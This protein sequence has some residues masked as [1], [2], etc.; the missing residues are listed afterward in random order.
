MSKLEDAIERQNNCVRFNT[1]QIP[2]IGISNGTMSNTNYVPPA[3]EEDCDEVDYDEIQDGDDTSA[4]FATNG[5][6]FLDELD[7]SMDS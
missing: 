7:G 2:M 3:Q 5:E 4:E 1:P 6:E